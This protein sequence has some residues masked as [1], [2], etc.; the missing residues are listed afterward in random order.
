MRPAAP[1]GAAG[2]LLP[3]FP[4]RFPTPVSRD[5]GRPLLLQRQPASKI[6]W[7]GGPPS[8]SWSPV[9]PITTTR[10][11]DLENR[12]SPKKWLGSTDE[13]RAV[14][15]RRGVPGVPVDRGPV[16]DAFRAHPLA[17]TEVD[18]RRVAVHLTE[19]HR[20]GGVQ[21]RTVQ[22]TLPVSRTLARVG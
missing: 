22:R 7:N 1:E 9:A 15:P 11:Q 17:A 2:L 21:P 5:L 18:D 14:Y 13:A 8:R 19:R 10:L 6:A 16:A 12:L 3:R 4:R 20:I